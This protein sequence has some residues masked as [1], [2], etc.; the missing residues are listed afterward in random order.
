MYQFPVTCRE[1]KMCD[2]EKTAKGLPLTNRNKGGKSSRCSA[3]APELSLLRSHS[4]WHITLI[5][6]SIEASGP[7]QTHTQPAEIFSV[8]AHSTSTQDFSVEVEKWWHTLSHPHQER[9]VAQLQSKLK[10]LWAAKEPNSYSALSRYFHSQVKRF[11]KSP[12]RDVLQ[13]HSE[14]DGNSFLKFWR[15]FQKGD[16]V[17]F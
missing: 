9:L 17:E 6:S 7:R 10:F 13:P 8:D 3:D 1:V 15:K 16:D 5:S 12:L 2:V 11:M 14:S 4:A